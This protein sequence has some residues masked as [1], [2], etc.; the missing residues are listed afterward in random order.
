VVTKIAATMCASVGLLLAGGCTGMIGDDSGRVND[1]DHQPT[2][3][4]ESAQCTDAVQP[5]RSPIRR[6]TRIEMDNAFRDLLGDTSKAAHAFVPE[7]E[8]LG[9]DNNA[10]AL[11][12]SNLLAEQVMEAAEK[13]ASTAAPKVAP[14]A[15]DQATC[16]RDFIKKWGKRAWRR[17]LTDDEVSALLA[18][19]EKGKVDGTYNDGI[20]LV[21]QRMIQSPYF[22]Y[23]FETGDVATLKDGVVQLT[24]YEQATRLSFFLWNTTPDEALM[25]KAEEGKL[26]TAEGIAAIAREMLKDPRAKESVANFHAQWLELGKLESVAKDPV[27]FPDFNAAMRTAMRAETEAFVD[28]VFWQNGSFDEFLT[29]PYTFVDGEKTTLDHRSGI[30]TMP[31]ILTLQAKS[32]QSSPVHRGKFVRERLLCMQLP[33][34]P[35]D[36]VIKPPDL[37][38]NLSTR[39]RFSEHSTNPAC[40]GCHKLMDPIGFGFENFDAIGRWRD[41]DGK[42]DVD[43][44]GEVFASNDADGKFVG[45]SDLGEKLAKSQQVKACIVTQWF[46]YAYGRGEAEADTCALKRLNE[47]FAKAGYDLR[48]LMVALTQSDAFRFRKAGAP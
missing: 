7:E 1:P 41:K 5:G 31:S 18:L 15:G 43:A 40:S 10:D 47:S 6:L 23:R 21:I 36:I 46:R 19:Y 11:G 24:P 20:A 38:P 45:V 17:P 22:I 8:S 34:P 28:H 13:L 30:L 44:N 14:C 42:F 12:M 2:N 29:A 32:N 39:Q 27:M 48:E 26:A 37:D 16:A 9:F 25:Q 35:N 4:T 33:P 3:T